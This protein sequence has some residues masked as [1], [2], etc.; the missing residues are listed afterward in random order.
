MVTGLGSWVW[1]DEL[2]FVVS[3][4]GPACRVGFVI[5]HVPQNGSQKNCSP[6]PGVL[7]ALLAWLR[8]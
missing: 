4:L 3:V 7:E 8:I 1:L 2:G 6:F 5:W